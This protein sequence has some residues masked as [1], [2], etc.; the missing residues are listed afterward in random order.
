[1]T[2][3]LQML[4]TVK[5]IPSYGVLATANSAVSIQREIL[6]NLLEF[7][8]WLNK[9]LLLLH[10]SPALMYFMFNVYDRNAISGTHFPR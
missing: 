9:I 5:Y 8:L 10:C 4:F 1:M 2:V 3:I 6:I 7:I